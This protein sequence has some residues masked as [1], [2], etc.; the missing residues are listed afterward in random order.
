[1]GLNDIVKDYGARGRIWSTCS[2]K[3]LRA[4]ISAMTT[5]GASF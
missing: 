4:W 5:A 3:P 2:I 1:M